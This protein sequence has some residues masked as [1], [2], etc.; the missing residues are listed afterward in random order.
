MCFEEDIVFK[1]IIRYVVW[2]VAYDCRKVDG[3]YAAVD[4]S[5]WLVPVES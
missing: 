1:R 2:C 5:I 3:L 4:L